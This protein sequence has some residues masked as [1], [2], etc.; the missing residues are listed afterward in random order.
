MTTVRSMTFGV[1]TAPST[2]V[3]KPDKVLYDE[4]IEDVKLAEA[5]GYE[6]VWMLEHH[7][8]DYYPTPSPLLFMAHVAALCPDIG[9]GTS[10]LVLPWY[11][12]VRIAEEISMLNSL[13]RGTLHLGLGRG[14]AKSEYDAY[15]VSMPEARGR[16]AESLDII[17]KGLS[18][19]E[20]THDGAYYKVPRPVRLRPEPVDK[21]VKF[22]GAI[23]SP[24]S[25]GVM[26]GLA[27]PPLCL[28]AFP[29][30]LLERILGTWD[31]SAPAGADRTKAISIK[32]LIADTDEEAVKLARRYFP[33]YFALQADHYEADANPWVNIE[34]YQ[35]FSRMFANLRKMADPDE[36]GP[37]CEMNLV[38]SPET[39]VERLK[40]YAALGFDYALVSAATPGMPKDLQREVMARFAR[41]V[42]PH[43]SPRFRAEAAE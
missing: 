15:G 26:A 2:D 16:F 13:T 6:S 10:V 25:A 4:V 34:E 31:E 8:S 19:Q 37:Y 30:R 35:Q 40:G 9:L 42:A 14:T 18:G 1:Q 7:F 24:Q 36:L 3:R 41:E 29:A 12:P 27:L 39:A 17:R 43:F 20:F 23:G 38:G 5:L 21:P 11:H 33:P 28:S 22:Y 32:M